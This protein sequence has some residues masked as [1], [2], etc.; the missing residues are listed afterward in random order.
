VQRGVRLKW[1]EVQKALRATLGAIAARDARREAFRQ[2]ARQLVARGQADRVLPLAGQLYT[3]PDADRAEALAVAG[4]EFLAAGDS[5]HAAQAGDQARA[6]YDAKQP[7]ALRAAVVALAMALGS[8]PPKAGK[9][10]E[11]DA[12]AVVG[13]AAGLARQGKWPQARELKRT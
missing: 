3:A 2:V 10:P 8:K 11:E 1:D 12:N 4:F 13:Q 7:P 6:A 5:A 9:G